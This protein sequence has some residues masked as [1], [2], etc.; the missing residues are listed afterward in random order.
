MTVHCLFF[1]HYQDIVGARDLAV[2]V[3]DNP[4][5]SDLAALLQ[6]RYPQLGNL[7]EQG[8]AAVDAEFAQA[9]FPLHDG[10]EVAWMPPMSGGLGG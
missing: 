1:A 4:T 2:T 5:V 9:D 10:A 6:G 7:L 3:G 8:R